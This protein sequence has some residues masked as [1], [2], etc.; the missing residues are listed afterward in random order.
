MYVVGSLTTGKEDEYG[1]WQW[2]HV[3]DFYH[4]SAYFGRCTV[5]VGFEDVFNCDVASMYL[6]LVDVVFKFCRGIIWGLF[7]LLKKFFGISVSVTSWS[8]LQ[9]GYMSL[10]VK[11]ANLELVGYYKRN[12][13]LCQMYFSLVAFEQYSSVT[14]DI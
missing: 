10:S 1:I 6:Q 9:P 14:K 4:S 7:W 12:S 11:T 3:L 2:Y 8:I 5:Q 13:L